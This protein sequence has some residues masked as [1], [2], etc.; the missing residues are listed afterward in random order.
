MFQYLSRRKNNPNI[1]L[2]AVPD[3][4]YNVS[5]IEMHQRALRGTMYGLGDI[6]RAVEEDGRVKFQYT[7]KPGRLYSSP[8]E[9]FGEAA[10]DGVTT[11]AR[12]TGRLEDSSLNLRGLA[13]LEQRLIEMQDYL[14]QNPAVSARLNI[15]DPSQI[16]F[17]TGTYKAPLGAKQSMEAITKR[18]KDRITGKIMG[19]VV[20]DD[21]E[22]N[23]LQVYVGEPGKGRRLA[24]DEISKL[25]SY[26]SEGIGGLFGTEKLLDALENDSL[27]S[28]FSKSPKRFR[29]LIGVRDLSLSGSVLSDILSAAG[30]S[31]SKLSEENVRVF[32]IKDDLMQIAENYQELVL[33]TGRNDFADN[34][35]SSTNF[36]GIKQY[37]ITDVQT[38]RLFTDNVENFLFKSNAGRKLGEEERLYYGNASVLDLISEALKTAGITGKVSEATDEQKKLLGQAFES[39]YDGT[40]VINEAYFR[41]TKNHLELELSTLKSMP[42]SAQIQAKILE[43][44][45]QLGNLKEGNFQAITTRTFFEY[46]NRPGMIKAVVDQSKLRGILAKYAMLVPDVAIKKEAGLMGRTSTMNLVLQGEPSGRVYYDPLAP[47]FHYNIF[48]SPEVIASQ[49][50]RQIRLTNSLKKAFETGEI[51]PVIRRQ[52]NRAAEYDKINELPAAQRASAERTRLYMRKLQEAIQSGVD[53]RTMPELFNYLLKTVQSDLYRVKDDFFQP[54]LEDAFRLSIDTEQSFLAGRQDHLGPTLGSGIRSI[55]MQGMS[56]PINAMEFTVRGHKM[57]IGGNAA[58]I[59]KHPLGGFDLDDKAIIMPRVLLDASGGQRLSTFI[60]R[61]PTGPGEFIFGTPKFSTTDTI[62][63]MLSNNDA[64]MDELDIINS[65]SKDEYFELIRDSLSATGLQKER[66]DRKLAKLSRRDAVDQVG[67]IESKIIDL[68]YRAQKRGNYSVKTIES[69][70]PI[71]DMLAKAAQKTGQGVASP[72]QLTRENVE[73]LLEQGTGF[74]D[75]QFLV[76]QYNYG[77]ILRVFKEEADKIGLDEVAQSELR[78]IL[79]GTTDYSLK[80]VADYIRSSDVNKAN[81]LKAVVESMYGRMSLDALGKSENIGQYVNKM[82]V[83][84][85]SSD[86]EDAIFTALRAAGK[87]AE[88]DE[89]IGKTTFGLL[90]PSDVVDMIT[91][92]GGKYRLLQTANQSTAQIMQALFDTDPIIAQRAFDRITSERGLAL[93]QQTAD[94]AIKA[95]FE[96]IG[97]LRAMAMEAGLSGDLVSGIDPEFL[98]AR[99]KSP[100]SMRAAITALESG[101][102]DQAGNLVTTNQ[103]MKDYAASIEAAKNVQDSQLTDELIRIAGMSSDSQYAHA[104]AMARLGKSAADNMSALDDMFNA[105]LTMKN[106]SEA[107]FSREATVL[108]ENILN[109]YAEMAGDSSNLLNALEKGTTNEAEFMKYQ[110]AVKQSQIGEKV[111]SMIMAAAE[112]SEGSTV[113]DILDN[114]ERLSL[115]SRMKHTRGYARLL[116]A[117]ENPNDIFNLVAA[118]Q[119]ARNIKSLER[120]QNIKSSADQLGQFMK[121]HRDANDEEKA[122]NI[123]MAKSMLEDFKSNSQTRATI[124]DA[125]QAAAFLISVQEDANVSSSLLQEDII[126]AKKIL[127]L[128]ESR[129]YL[130]ALKMGDTAMSDVLRFGG[131]SSASNFAPPPIDLD[132]ETRAKV[133]AGL[134]DDA[135]GAQK[136]PSSYKRITESWRDGK[137]GEAFGNPIVKKSAYAVAGLI[138]ASFI[139]SATKDRGEQE[140]AGPPLLP[141][142]SAYESMPQRSPQIPNQSMFSGYDRGNSYTVHVEGSRDQAEAFRQ[143]AGSVAKGSINSTMSRGLPRLGRDPYSEVAGSF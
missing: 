3:E 67:V 10:K 106:M 39:A 24:V 20:P 50:K 71:M 113:Q 28:L 142:G 13:G 48:S 59:F 81:E 90:A 32:N 55:H 140:I 91:N 130:A 111:R 141:G 64:L 110:S 102:A 26:T 62:K 128:S 115:T 57:L 45:S 31:G 83:A 22:F 120:N 61:Q 89:I 12:V 112:G 25:F 16:Y 87:D 38:G 94:A 121:A 76:N 11:F 66:L 43:L 30:M 80:D 95:K 15:N 117:G 1:G 96:R 41:A 23:L 72:I 124:D 99:L 122:Y 139:Y 107:N 49:E 143:S 78:G 137:L 74:I 98:K 40:A 109:Q 68:M 58:Q 33:K 114:M 105:R 36:G 138:A 9:A 44:E 65:T 63:M 42:Q 135:G 103:S 136:A 2:S 14:S 34:I 116:T 129:R 46:N 85:A 108:A 70:D 126:A 86:Q 84:T 37:G 53:I 17:E 77:S 29:G 132:E 82:L 125:R 47:A 104:S 19:L 123:R 79:G 101:F 54:A 97:R 92:M 133:F 51:D 75:E 118:A 52:I 4:L 7:R 27:G 18:L 35:T 73:R 100:D 69:T 134:T 88:V 127:Q 21:S 6:I 131:R 60:F 93:S 119:H 56:T 5:Y 8:Q